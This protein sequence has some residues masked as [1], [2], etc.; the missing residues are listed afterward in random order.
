MEQ[1]KADKIAQF[2]VNGVGSTT[3]NLF[4]LPFTYEESAVA[5]IP[6]PWEVTV[7]YKTGT[8]NGPQAVL[9]ASPQLD[10]YDFDYPK[11][12]QHGFFM[13]PIDKTWLQKNEDLRFRAANYIK[14]L[15]EGGD[16][17]TH[18]GMQRILEEINEN[19]TVLKDWVKEQCQ[20]F[21]NDGKIP[22]VLGGDHSTPIGLLEALSEKYQQFGILQIDAH[23][24]LRKAYEGFTYSHAS[25]MYNAVQ[26]PSVSKLIAVGVRDVCEAEVT[27]AKNNEKIT[28]F[29]DH[30]IKQAVRIVCNKTW[31]QQ[32]QAIIDELPDKV[33]VSFDIDGLMPSLCPNTG[34]P[35]VGG[36]Q[37]YE[38]V[39]LLQLL[40][41]SDRKII[42]AD[43][44][45]VAPDTSDK[46]NEWD[47]NV[48]A[49]ILY[50]LCTYAAVAAQK[51]A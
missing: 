1:S 45:E 43:L 10:L 27:F 19:C 29:Y 4:G 26:L 32:C 47:A 21:I 13:L 46:A 41:K 9:N 15:E 22:M 39:Y 42:G 2:D 12:W 44:C 37:F 33:Y 14:F 20:M 50:K 17:E 8:A 36:L 31:H 24:D 6:V 16:I 3:G 25:I 35:V 11:A 5:I 23:A 34:T 49:R 7:S 51:S 30:E 40:I 18:Q 38:A 28:T 48:G